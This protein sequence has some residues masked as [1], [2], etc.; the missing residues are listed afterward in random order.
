METASQRLPKFP[1]VLPSQW[2]HLMT[3]RSRQVFDNAGHFDDW[4]DWRGAGLPTTGA[5]GFG[6]DGREAGCSRI[7]TP[8]DGGGFQQ[9]RWLMD[10]QFHC[11]SDHWH[12]RSINIL[13]SPLTLIWQQ[14]MNCRGRVLHLS[15]QRVH[16]SRES[17]KARVEALQAETPTLKKKKKKR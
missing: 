17:K 9:R 12:F 1:T 7:S 14:L 5:E 11:R 8:I 6:I 16:H 2:W 10:D 13:S 15:D 3:P 4:T